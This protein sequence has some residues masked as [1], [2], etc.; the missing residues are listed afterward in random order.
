MK[1]RPTKSEREYMGRVAELGCIICRRPAQIHHIRAGSG[2]GQRAAHTDIL[3]L[4]SEH[5]LNGGHGVAIHAG[6]RTWEEKYGTELELLERVKKEVAVK[7]RLDEWDVRDNG[8]G[9]FLGGWG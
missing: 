8:T 2:I 3:P 9:P 6:R 5:H 1:K 7:K 4:C